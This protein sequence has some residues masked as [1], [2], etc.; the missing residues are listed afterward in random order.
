MTWKKGQ[1]G[2]PAGR[3]P[4][5]G[6]IERLRGQLAE[7]IPE[8]VAK[9]VEQARAGDTGA[10]RLLL[11][12]VVP[13]LRGVDLPV[14]LP[15]L[16]TTTSLADAGRAVVQAAGAGVLSPEQAGRL[17]DGLGAQ[18]RLVEMDELVKRVEALE[19][20]TATEHP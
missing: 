19:E 17:L 11:E 2:N 6:A 9:L 14:T 8:V 10:A 3:K 4:G 1:S 7:H 15:G 16:L 13:P 18:A 5:T 20:R 12:R